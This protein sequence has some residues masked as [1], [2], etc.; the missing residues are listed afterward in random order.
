MNTLKTTLTGIGLLFGLTLSA[1]KNDGHPE[2]PF[3]NKIE[4]SDQ[5]LEALFLAPENI[6]M[7]LAPGL[8]LQGKIQNK[9]VHGNSVTSLLIKVE[10]QPGGTLS[11]SRY[12]DPNGKIYYAGRLLKLHEPDGMMLIE[13]DQRYF[14]LETQQR[15]L[16]AE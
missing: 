9:S 12:R 8:R 16:V 14:F 15:F 10:S 7:E 1:Q 13:K 3:S 6:N 11:I 4:V 5:A 2:L